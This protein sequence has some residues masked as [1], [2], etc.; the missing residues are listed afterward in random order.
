LTLEQ[1]AGEI[2]VKRDTEIVSRLVPGNNAGIMACTFIGE[3]QAAAATSRGLFLWDAKTGKL[4]QQFKGHRLYTVTASPD[5]RYLIA[6]GMDQVIDV[7]L[8]GRDQP[9]LS[10][11]FAPNDWIAWTPEGYYAA[12]PGGEHLMGWQVNNGLEQRATFHT[13]NRFRKTLYRPDVITRLLKAGNIDKALEEADRAAG[14]QTKRLDV[15][16]VLP[17]RV[18]ITAPEKS[19][20]RVSSPKLVVKA[21][22]ESSGQ[23]PVTGLRLL[24]DGRPYEGQRDVA[25]PRVGTVEKEWSVTLTP[26]E[27]RL[28]VLAQ[29]AVSKATSEPVTVTYTAAPAAN[30]D[31]PALHVLSVGI[32]AYAGDWKLGCAVNDARGIVGAF[33]KQSK[34]LF[35][36]G[37]RS[38]L[39][40]GEKRGDKDVTRDGILKGLDWLKEARPQDLAVVF[41]AGHG[42][43]DS[44]SGR[45]YMLAIDLD[46]DNLD[47]TS[48]TG[49]D[50]K[51]ALMDLPC[52]VVLMMDACH[53][54]GV[55]P[56]RVKRAHAPLD[57]L[58]RSFA[59]EEVGVVVWVAAQG[60]ETSREDAKLNH[61]YFTLAVMEGLAGKAGMNKKGEVHLSA[62]DQYVFD[63]VTDMS[64]DLQH[65][66]MGRP[67]FIYS[68]ALARPTAARK[69]KP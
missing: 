9:L 62:L 13:A 26:G 55:G 50:L 33:E 68:F 52:R 17:P 45:F 46:P 51:K 3:N 34:D 8:P 40:L 23:H 14:K 36:R 65:P 20:Q 39:L 69:P 15:E 42:H 61:G 10:F 12:S 21:V 56:L 53:S 41:Y 47:K 43:T 1:K 25:Q 28:A 58:Q 54:A 38:K 59:D 16:Q 19:G 49:D 35:P 18:A 6:G 60:P 67:P 66:S 11:F 31:D 22:A 30:D 27:H 44:S 57:G 29:S 48:V 37:T 4:L 5:D 2:S 7:W 64:N 24:L 63:R 32:D